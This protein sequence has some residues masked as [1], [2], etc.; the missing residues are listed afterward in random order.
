M[1]ARVSELLQDADLDQLRRCKTSRME[2]VHYIGKP[3]T[4]GGRL[5]QRVSRSDGIQWI[6]T[7]SSALFRSGSNVSSVNAPGSR[8]EFFISGPSTLSKA[9]AYDDAPHESSTREGLID[10]Y[11]KGI[12]PPKPLISAR[13]QPRPTL[14]CFN[15]SPI[16]QTMVLAARI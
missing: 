1:L 15:P 11:N 16:R 6:P 2:A 8:K 5:D 7:I 12:H 10:Y 4:T 13:T 9:A 3:A 14:S